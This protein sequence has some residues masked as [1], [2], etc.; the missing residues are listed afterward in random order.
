MNARNLLSWCLS[1]ALWTIGAILLWKAWI[2]QK[3]LPDPLGSYI[4]FGI[5]FVSTFYILVLV[6]IKTLI[7]N[8]LNIGK[9]FESAFTET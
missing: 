9:D 2:Y 7:N 5:M 4:E 1:L 6:V 8:L 3:A